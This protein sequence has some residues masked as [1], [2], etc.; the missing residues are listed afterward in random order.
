MASNIVHVT[1]FLYIELIL[2]SS[3]LQQTEINHFHV[4]IHRY[5]GVLNL[6][7]FPI[8]YQI[9]YCASKVDSPK[10]IYRINIYVLKNQQWHLQAVNSISIWFIPKVHVSIH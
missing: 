5:D 8:T 6:I 9:T 2:C 3:T 7:E 1:R 10:S 4:R